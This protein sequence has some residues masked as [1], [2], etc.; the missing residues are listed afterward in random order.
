MR[1]LKKAKNIY[2]KKLSHSDWRWAHGGRPGWIPRAGRLGADLVALVLGR[3]AWLGLA[4]GAG[5]SVL[6]VLINSRRLLKKLSQKKSNRNPR[7]T[8]VGAQKQGR[9]RESGRAFGHQSEINIHRIV[10]Y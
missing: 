1:M 7:P 5:A 9:Y 10:D 3:G 4:S 2:I 8:A 6:P